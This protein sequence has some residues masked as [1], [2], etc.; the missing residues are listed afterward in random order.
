MR[1]FPCLCCL[2]SFFY[3]KPQ[4]LY[5]VFSLTVGCL[6]SFFYIK[7]QPTV[8]QSY[9]LTVVLY[10][11]STSN[12]N[13]EQTS[14]FAW[15]VVLYPSS[16]SNHNSEYKKALSWK[17]F[18]ILLLHQTTTIF[19][20]S[21]VPLLLFY[22]LLL[23]QT[24]TRHRLYMRPMRCFIS[25]FYIKPQLLKWSSFPYWVVL[26]PSSTSNHN[27]ES[28]IMPVR[29]VVLYP[30]STSNHN[31]LPS[32]AWTW[33]LF[34]I[35]LLHQTTTKWSFDRLLDCCFISF[36]YIKPQLIFFFWRCKVVVLYPSSTSNHNRKQGV[37][38][39]K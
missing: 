30:S 8:L 19:T 29:E 3:I 25:F 13:L 39:K 34:Y 18:Y 6:I 21:N 37:S 38:V 2:I 16:T 35:L 9:K 5:N 17:L 36:F 12:H 14:N 23:H 26:Y 20:I 24:T 11:S 15:W 4:P 32:H 31:H 28:L 10:P 27:F 7:P 33:E 1:G 22:I